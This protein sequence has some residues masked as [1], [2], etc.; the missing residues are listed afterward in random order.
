MERVERVEREIITSRQNRQVKL[1]CSLC[2]KKKRSESGLFRVDG[3][4]LLYEIL[5]SSYELDSIFYCQDAGDDVMSCI[6]AA[7][8]RGK[9]KEE[10]IVCVSESV[11]D[12]MTEQSAPEGIIAVARMGDIHIMACSEEIDRVVQD[13]ERLLMLESIRDP[14]NLGT[15]IRSAYA[16]GIDTVI[17]SDDCADIYNPKTLRAAM[18]AIFRQKTVRVDSSQLAQSIDAL[19]RTGRKVFATALTPE[20]VSIT[21]VEF[22]TGDCFV[23]GNEGHGLSE[24][25]LNSCTST[26]IIPMREGAESLNAASAATI[27]IWETVRRS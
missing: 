27:C 2:D 13:R 10:R 4:K 20:A 11:F 25:T 7:L 9:I 3:I 1:V 5:D 8:A 15:I 18:G 14:G 22:C 16:L 17:I 23:I 24:K 12:K 19:V 21:D 26:V 6:D